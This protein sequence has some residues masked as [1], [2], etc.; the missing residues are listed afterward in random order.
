MRKSTGS[1]PGS[2]RAFTAN[3]NIAMESAEPP[4]TSSSTLAMLVGFGLGTG[5]LSGGDMA[6]V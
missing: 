6:P 5:G 1:A 3:K 2:T 4:A